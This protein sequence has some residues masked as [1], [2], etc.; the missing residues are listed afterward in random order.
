MTISDENK[1]VVFNR[2]DFENLLKLNFSFLNPELFEEFAEHE[3]P[4]AVIIRRQDQFASPCL[5]TYAAMISIVAANHPNKKISSELQS[6]ADYFHEQGVLA[7]EEGWK[8][9]TP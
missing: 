4:D 3:I 9:P 8:L 5:L 2:A 7:G 1:Y 6:I